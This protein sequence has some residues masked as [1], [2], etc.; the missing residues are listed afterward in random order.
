MGVQPADLAH[1][2]G[3]TLIPLAN[4]QWS[5]RGR[6]AVSQSVELVLDQ[7]VLGLDNDDLLQAP[8]E[9]KGPL[10]FDGPHQP[11]LVDA[12]ARGRRIGFGQ[13]E[14]LQGVD[15]VEI[16]LAS[17][18]D[19]D[20]TAGSV[21]GDPVET[22]GPRESS[23]GGNALVPYVVFDLE[24]ALAKLDRGRLHTF[25]GHEYWQAAEVDRGRG[26]HQ[27]VQ[28]DHADP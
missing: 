12:D 27:V 24:P 18:D 1:Q 19:P 20:T 13:P 8:H 7:G 21:D 14:P 2:R 4:D 23:D 11:E 15:H 10:V 5:V 3:A 22:I 28:G 16:G 17:D 6:Q 9:V 26:V 25:G